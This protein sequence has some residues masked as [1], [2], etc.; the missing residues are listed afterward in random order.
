MSF[1]VE[2]NT[3][4]V[5]ILGLFTTLQ[6]MLQGMVEEYCKQLSDYAEAHP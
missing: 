2:P 3:L 1:D 5:K 6:K 4:G